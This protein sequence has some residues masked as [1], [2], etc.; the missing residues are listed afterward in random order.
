MQYEDLGKKIFS[1]K[2]GERYMSLL[3]SEDGQKLSRMLDTDQIERAAKSGDTGQLQQILSK[4]LA[5]DEGKRLAKQ[6]SKLQN[7]K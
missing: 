6:I 1:G 3:E 2:D 4:V 5:T 7:D